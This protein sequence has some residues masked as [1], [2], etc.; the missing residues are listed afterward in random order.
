MIATI[1]LDQGLAALATSG[2]SLPPGA[3]NKLH[4]YLALLVKWN[5][6]YNL[7]AIRD[8]EQ[9]I[10]H[11]VLDA[12]AVLPQSKLSKF[13]RNETAGKAFLG[14]KQYD[15]AARCLEDAVAE[16]RNRPFLWESLA[17]A[18]EKQGKFRDAS[19]A[20]SSAAGLQPTRKDLAQR[21]I[22]LRKKVDGGPETPATQPK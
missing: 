14:L 22:D 13:D 21:A 9:M 16:V 20:M 18:Y 6:V 7:T 11:H 10:T 12:L 3:R 4:A 1:D 19:R 17:N 15:K 5:N 8:P 2:I